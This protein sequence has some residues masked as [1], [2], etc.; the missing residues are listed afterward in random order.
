[1]QNF[2]MG[3]VPPVTFGAG[4]LNKLPDLAASLANGPVFVVA[5]TVLAE[6]GV[7]DRVERQ[8]FDEGM[9]VQ[10]AADVAGEPKEALVDVLS[11][12]A[13]SVGAK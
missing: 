4:Q 9:S 2:N 8:M 5:D 12:R 13:R 10:I 6:L 3:K 7:T 11:E 1:M